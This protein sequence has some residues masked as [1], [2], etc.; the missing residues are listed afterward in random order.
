[1]D[2]NALKTA[3]VHVARVAGIKIMD[4]HQEP[5]EAE[6][7][8]GGSPVAEADAEAKAIVLSSLKF[9]LVAAGEADVYPLFGRTMA[10]DTGAGH[11]VLVA[12]GGRVTHPDTTDFTFGKTD[13]RNGAFIA[14]GKKNDPN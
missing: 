7:K 5:A 11:A 9:C 4:V 1:M 2:L 14:W 12:A 6:C 8:G 10:W 13:C 3:L